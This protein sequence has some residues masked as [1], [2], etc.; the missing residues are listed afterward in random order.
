MRFVNAQ[1]VSYIDCIT[2][3][4]WFD[5]HIS[6]FNANHMKEK[7]I[8]FNLGIYVEGTRGYG[9]FRIDKSKVL[10]VYS[11]DF[12]AENAYNSILIQ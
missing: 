11:M 8:L 3:A 10:V 5:T 1:F 2:L 9:F 7:L 6:D 12:F 4:P